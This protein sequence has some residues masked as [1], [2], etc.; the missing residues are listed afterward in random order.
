MRPE[1]LPSAAAVNL[2]R[3]EGERSFAS[4]A[5][6]RA[7]ILASAILLVRVYGGTSSGSLCARLVAPARSD[8]V[9]AQFVYGLMAFWLSVVSLSSLCAVREL[10]S[11]APL[12]VG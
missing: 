7:A 8:S 3:V 1:A 6:Y 4:C 10:A 11:W 5:A 9:C 2:R 12:C